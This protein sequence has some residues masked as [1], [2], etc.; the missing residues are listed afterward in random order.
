[1]ID[2]C[3]VYSAIMYAAHAE[4]KRK[5]S[6]QIC[7]DDCLQLLDTAKS[8]NDRFSAVLEI[9]EFIQSNSF[10]DGDRGQLLNSMGCKFLTKLI[11]TTSV[12]PGWPRDQYKAMAL[13]VLS[14]LCVD[15]HFA[16]APDMEVYLPEVNKIISSVISSGPQDTDSAGNSLVSQMCEDC[17]NI[18][19]HVSQHKTGV[20]LLTQ[21]IALSSLVDFACHPD[22]VGKSSVLSTLGNVVKAQGD[23]LFVD[24]EEEFH[25]VMSL[26]VENLVNTKDIIE[27]L[28]YAKTLTSLL[29]GMSEMEADVSTD[30]VAKL[31]KSLKKL[32][33]LKLNSDL[34][35]TLIHLVGAFVS[36]V[37]PDVLGTKVTGDTTFLK[38]VV[39]RLAVETYVLLDCISR[40]NALERYPTMDKVYKLV[41]SVVQFIAN[42]EDNVMDTDAIIAIYRKLVD[43]SQTLMDFL[44][45][46]ANQEVQLPR[47]HVVVLLSV[48]TLAAMLTEITEDP[49]EQLLELLPFFNLLC[50]NVEYSDEVKMEVKNATQAA[51]ANIKLMGLNFF[52]TD[53]HD[54][55][56][57]DSQPSEHPVPAIDRTLNV[58]HKQFQHEHS[59]ALIPPIKSESNSQILKDSSLKSDNIVNDV[60][61]LNITDHDNSHQ[62]KQNCD[63]PQLKAKK[64]SFKQEVLVREIPNDLQLQSSGCTE[65]LTENDLRNN[66]N[67]QPD[68]SKNSVT[69]HISISDESM[70]RY[71][72]F[73]ESKKASKSLPSHLQRQ[74]SFFGKCKKSN[75]SQCVDPVI[76]W[77][78]DPDDVLGF[79]LPTY[80]FLLEHDAALQILVKFDAFHTVVNFIQKSLSLLLESEDSAFPE[81]TTSNALTVIEAVYSNAP[82]IAAR[83]DCLQ[84]LFEISVLSLP[85]L[86]TL[87]HPPALVSLKLIEVALVAYKLQNKGHKRNSALPRLKHSQP[88]FFRATLEYLS[89][90]YSL[91]RSKWQKRCVVQVSRE[92]QDIWPMVEDA[93]CASVAGVCTLIHGVDDLCDALLKSPII[94]DL[95]TFLSDCDEKQVYKDGEQRLVD[96]LLSL[97]ES[98]AAGSEL[99]CDLMLRHHGQQVASKFGLQKMSK[100]LRT[101][102]Q[103]RT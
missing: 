13:S 46:V 38:S 20:E 95:L 52:P 18:L 14:V 10:T 27:K 93:W 53:H 67:S 96:S 25:L 22:C 66:K 74:G 79:L 29:A 2:K 37:G 50:Q 86:V 76:Q 9:T 45:S 31:A 97:L 33:L 73:L 94:P 99:L 102:K 62:D 16:L 17:I 7:L 21:H 44:Y 48:R 70:Q 3:F 68:N 34:S 19:A 24:R 56:S 26:A 15:P 72:D 77:H 75:L 12:V 47:N 80:A 36:A 32:L 78:P 42:S 23:G 54:D 84:D 69:E 91:H 55:S 89:S 57:V 98:S 40:D 82:S 28:N 64:I 43:I 5:E 49:T 60:E 63:S 41:C 92:S 87:A 8:D 101:K 39:A 90:F 59:A 100:H 30:W 35:Q 58:K 88:R 81:S 61:K 1:V 6:S 83:L 4:K 11:T 85:N 51:L 65:N 103:S 71:R